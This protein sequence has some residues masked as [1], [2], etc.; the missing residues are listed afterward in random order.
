M[1]LW[2]VKAL[3]F[4]RKLYNIFCE[5]SY[6]L[7][8][9]IFTFLLS[10]VAS[11]VPQAIYTSSFC[12]SATLLT[13]SKAFHW[14]LLSVLLIWSELSALCEWRNS[15]QSSYVL[16]PLYALD[17][18]LSFRPSSAALLC[19]TKASRSFISPWFCFHCTLLSGHDVIFLYIVRWLHVL[20]DL[21]AVI[22]KKYLLTVCSIGIACLS[23]LGKV[24]LPPTTEKTLFWIINLLYATQCGVLSAEGFELSKRRTFI[25]NTR[26][27]STETQRFW[28]IFF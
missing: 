9:L 18:S 2:H 5:N 16:S 1:V 3:K 13:L 23:N 8:L 22:A 4:E 15:M 24:G 19:V 11:F 17:Y 27:C 21:V 26:N 28:C 7:F 10:V 25:S 14:W 6:S 20:P 12:W